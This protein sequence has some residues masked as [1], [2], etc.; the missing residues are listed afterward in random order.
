[1]SLSEYFIL[2]TFFHNFAAGITLDLDFKTS[3]VTR[4]GEDYLKIK[5]INT[6]ADAKQ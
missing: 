4:D 6:V 3:V 2:I 1:M 5:R